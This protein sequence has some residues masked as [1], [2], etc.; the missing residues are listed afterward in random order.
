MLTTFRDWL[1]IS[2]RP[3]ELR[4]SRQTRAID[5]DIDGSIAL[6]GSRSGVIETPLIWPTLYIDKDIDGI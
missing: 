6:F 4:R 3:I 5:I 2:I 1:Q